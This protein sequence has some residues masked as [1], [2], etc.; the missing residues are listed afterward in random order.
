MANQNDT[1]TPQ[2]G[3]VVVIAILILIAY[4]AAVLFLF[5]QSKTALNETWTRYT[6]LL[7]GIEAIAFSAVG[8]LFG[9]EVHRQQAENAEKRAADAQKQAT[10]ASNEAAAVRSKG[11]S[12]ANWIRA[13]TA[14]QVKAAVIAAGTAS[15]AASSDWE[16]AATFADSLFPGS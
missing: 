3:I 12:L 10:S 14:S 5:I 6:L 15:A 9:K 7:G 2:K 16:Q 13:K 11:Q 8:Y 4:A 1:S